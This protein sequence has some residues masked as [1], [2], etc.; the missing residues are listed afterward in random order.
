MEEE[1]NDNSCPNASSST[2]SS[3]VL[4]SGI[5][6]K[7]EMMEDRTLEYQRNLD[8]ILDHYTKRYEAQP[9]KRQ[10]K[11]DEKFNRKL[12]N[13]VDFHCEYGHWQVPSTTGKKLYNWVGQLHRL[14]RCAYYN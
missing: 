12:Q 13:L 3:K 10:K 7:Q 11:K 5:N 1:R 8:K 2:A 14:F 6:I 4:A 9:E